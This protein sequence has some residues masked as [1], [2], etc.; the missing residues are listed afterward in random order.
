VIIFTT[1]VWAYVSIV[2]LT[3]VLVVMNIDSEFLRFQQDKNKVRLCS[4]L[5]ALLVVAS[6]IFVISGEVV[7]RVIDSEAVLR[8]SRN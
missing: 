2:V 1:S 6:F 4:Y 7:D 3:L 8:V 5:T